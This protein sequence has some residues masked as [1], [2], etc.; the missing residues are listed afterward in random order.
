V[1]ADCVLVRVFMVGVVPATVPTVL[2]VTSDAHPAIIC[3]V[4]PLLPDVEYDD[5]H[6]PT[7]VQ[8]ESTGTWSLF[9]QLLDSD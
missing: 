7:P 9:V 2:E 1:I 8:F 6:S 5:L 3:E 4:P